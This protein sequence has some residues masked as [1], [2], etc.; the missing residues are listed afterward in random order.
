M[1]SPK[2]V[3]SCKTFLE[4]NGMN[5]RKSRRKSSRKSR[6]KSSRKSRRKSSRKSD[7]ESDLIDRIDSTINDFSKSF[8]YEI[9]MSDSTK[10]KLLSLLKNI[11]YKFDLGELPYDKKAKS[12][13]T[14]I[15]KNYEQNSIT[16]NLKNELKL[17]IKRKRKEDKYCVFE[18]L[19]A[20]IIDGAIRD[21]G[22][23]IKNITY[24]DIQKVIKDDEDLSSFIMNK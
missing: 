19:V 13:S 3:L 18:L 6:R 16:E 7:S 22:G 20:E 10:T 5:V 12:L 8:D 23:K 21:S 9:K 17:V 2:K 11:A 1:S 24:N 15:D 4:K 14:L